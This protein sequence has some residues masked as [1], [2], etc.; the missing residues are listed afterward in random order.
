MKNEN[1]IERAIRLI[2]T[3]ANNSS[4]PIDRE[5]LIGAIGILFGHTNHI[6]RIPDDQL[7]AFEIFWKDYPCKEQKK[8]AF[9]K[10]KTNVDYKN[11][12]QDL[13]D[14]VKKYKLVLKSQETKTFTRSPMLAAR[15]L[16][17]REWT[18]Y[19]AIEISETKQIVEVNKFEFFSEFIQKNMSSDIR[20]QYSGMWDLRYS[21]FEDCEKDYLIKTGSYFHESKNNKEMEQIIKDNLEKSNVNEVNFGKM[22]ASLGC[23]YAENKYE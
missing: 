3:L 22:M 14:S 16:G 4:D 15:F 12:M 18:S 1:N 7:N 17:K 10:F 19:L 13:L 6:D 5:S 20:N 9:Q 8:A 23:K 2:N 21:F 11:E